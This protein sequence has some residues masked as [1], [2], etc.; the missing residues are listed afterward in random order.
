MLISYV[1][2]LNIAECF[3]REIACKFGNQIIAVYAI[4]SL[5]SDYYR[6]GQSD[7]DTAVITNCTRNNLQPLSSEIENIADTYWDKY[8][9]PKGFGAIV[10]ADEQLY[11]PYIKNEELILEILRLKT[12]SRLL[13]GYYD[14]DAIPTPTK[15]D[16][17]EDACAFQK[18]ADE[19]KVRNPN[20][21]IDS[22]Q[23]FVNSS[24]I[25]LK[26]Y[27]MIKHGIIEFNKFKVI[28]LYLTHDPPFVND[29]IFAFI[30]KNLNGDTTKCNDVKFT[31]MVEWHDE[32][33]EVI[34]KLVL[35]TE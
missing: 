24:L 3:S 9:V 12:Q 18:W 15:H 23:T 32:L 19:E 11:P 4:G 1:D 2:A 17:I 5:A 30:N 22:I 26:R 13:Y 27:L 6:P 14:V 31:Q 35:Y 7:I 29:E 20:F 34:N 21:K 16:I 8:N 33:Y 25:A 28:D 10:F